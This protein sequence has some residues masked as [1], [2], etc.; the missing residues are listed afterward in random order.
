MPNNYFIS[1]MPKSGKTTLLGKLVERLKERGLKVGGFLSPE[2]KM[3]GARTGFRVQ[4]IDSGKSVRLAALDIDGPK[5]A[6][7]HVDMKSFDSLV[8]PILRNHPKY[9]IIIIDEIGRMEMK[10]TKFQDLLEELLESP[11][12]L[13]ASLHRDYIDDY[14]AWGEVLFLTPSNRGRVLMDLL[15]KAEEYSPKPKAAVKEAKKVAKKGAG[16]AKASKR[17]EGKK[18]EKP[19]KAKKGADGKKSQKK[20]QGKTK[21]AVKEKPKKKRE[22]ISRIADDIISHHRK[23]E[24]EQHAEKK[25]KKSEEKNEEAEPAEDRGEQ[26]KEESQNEDKPGWRGWVQE[27]IGV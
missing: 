3:H 2:D 4:D 20:K 19:K 24:R 6:K 10:S 22:N 5:V 23:G 21:A 25:E 13:I 27:H 17:K 14:A 9:D 26:S 16:G 12:P 15:R 18:K 1:G 7:Y 11:T 8:A